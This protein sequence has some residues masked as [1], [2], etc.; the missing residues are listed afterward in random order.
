[1]GKIWPI[2]DFYGEAQK[3]DIEDE[4]VKI[5]TEIINTMD[6]VVGEFSPYLFQYI[7]AYKNSKYSEKVYLKLFNQYLFKADFERHMHEIIR[8]LIT[9]KEGLL[10]AVGN[11]LDKDGKM[12]SLPFMR[13]T[14]SNHLVIVQNAIAIYGTYL[15]NS[16]NTEFF[17]EVSSI[18]MRLLPSKQEEV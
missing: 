17:H 10:Y 13:T 2:L 14:L 15:L 12:K 11:L 18:C 16:N 9:L 5:A 7:E 6:V 4:V 8:V 3:Y 1:M